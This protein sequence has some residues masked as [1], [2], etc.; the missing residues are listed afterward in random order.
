LSAK[1]LADARGIQEHSSDQ[2]VKRFSMRIPQTGDTPM[3]VDAKTASEIIK[4]RMDKHDSTQAVDP[5][6]IH[7]QIYLNHVC[8]FLHLEANP[9]NLN[10]VTMALAHY[11]I[12][13]DNF[14]EYPKEVDGQV[15]HSK[16]EHDA[17]IDPE[18][19]EVQ[20]EPVDARESET[21]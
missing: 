18:P 20:E 8:Q 9:A 21:A 10:K 15:V 11:G 3:K 1:D 19:A 14:Q 12:E 2:D 6:E 16:E 5:I 13:A 7:R 17:S 4:P